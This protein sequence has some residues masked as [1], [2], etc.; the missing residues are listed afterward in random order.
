M[1]NTRF[2]LFN[3]GAVVLTELYYDIVTKNDDE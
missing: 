1:H 2:A 3:W